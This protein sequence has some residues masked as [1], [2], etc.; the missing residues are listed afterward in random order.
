MDVGKKITRSSTA[1]EKI[2]NALEKIWTGVA[3][4]TESIKSLSAVVAKISKSIDA[5]Q[6]DVSKIEKDSSVNNE[7]LS[8][9]SPKIDAYKASFQAISDVLDPPVETDESLDTTSSRLN[10]IHVNSKIAEPFTSVKNVT[11]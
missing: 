9:I 5:L 4:N 8:R 11:R 7:I 6:V 3:A 1:D 10:E 2:C